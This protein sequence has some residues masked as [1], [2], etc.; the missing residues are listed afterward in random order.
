MSSAEDGR[1]GG[2]NTVVVVDGRK[3]LHTL[4]RTRDGGPWEI[5]TPRS[6]Q[7]D[8]RDGYTRETGNTSTR[9]PRSMLAPEPANARRD[10]AAAVN[11]WRPGDR[12]VPA[13]RINGTAYAEVWQLGGGIPNITAA[14]CRQILDRMAAAADVTEVPGIRRVGDALHVEVETFRAII[15]RS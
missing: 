1:A 12:S 15:G 3:K 13:L 9:P 6:A 10:A 8:R 2:I 5:A 7:Q 11:S 4:A 14:K